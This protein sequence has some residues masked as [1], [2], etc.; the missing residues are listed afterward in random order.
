MA[1]LGPTTPKI[2]RFSGAPEPHPSRGPTMWEGSRSD[3]LETYT[4][5]LKKNLAVSFGITTFAVHY[6]KI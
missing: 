3:D 1:T 6:A 5:L 4:L 2:N